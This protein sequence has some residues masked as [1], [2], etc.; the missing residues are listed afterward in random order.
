MITQH[1]SKQP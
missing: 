1:H